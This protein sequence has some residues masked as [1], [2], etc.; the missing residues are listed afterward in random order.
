MTSLTPAQRTELEA[1]GAGVADQLEV[2]GP[3][4]ADLHEIEDLPPAIALEVAAVRA[5]AS[6][7]RAERQTRLAVARARA[8]GMSWHK[9]ALPL[10]LTAEGARRKYRG[11]LAQI[12]A[13]A[14]VIN[15]T[16]GSNLSH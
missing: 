16:F 7:A 1:F 6:T 8:A 12:N 10:H 3:D 15:E 9:I 11:D 13:H 2:G 5:A 4:P 14:S